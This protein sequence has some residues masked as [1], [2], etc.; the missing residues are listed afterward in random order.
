MF[1]YVDH[2]VHV[3]CTTVSRLLQFHCN[4]LP[5]QLKYVLNHQSSLTPEDIA[6]LTVTV[7]NSKIILFTTSGL[8]IGIQLQTQATSDSY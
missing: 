5:I 6:D 4:T 2:V 3:K 8:Q 1:M 7:L